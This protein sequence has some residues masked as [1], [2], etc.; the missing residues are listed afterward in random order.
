MLQTDSEE[1][2]LAPDDIFF[3][4]GYHRG[5]VVVYNIYKFDIPLCRYDICRAEIK[6]IREVLPVKG[7]LF[8]DESHQL[9]LA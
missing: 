3:M 8:Y 7:Y 2:E 4:M 5:M 1:L 6:M 9:T